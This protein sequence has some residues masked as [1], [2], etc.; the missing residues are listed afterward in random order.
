M[1]SIG[2]VVAGTFDGSR[3]VRP[4]ADEHW[5]AELKPISLDFDPD[6]LAVSGLDRDRLLIEG[7]DCAEAM[8]DLAKWVSSIAGRR[9]PVLAAYPLSYDW[10]FLYWYFVRFSTLG[11]PF[12]HSRCFD[13]KTAYAVKGRRTIGRSGRDRLPSELRSSLA[14]THHALDDAREQAEIFA[15]LFEWQPG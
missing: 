2:V 14:H 9:T 7:R 11:C 10:T 1:L 3:F 15:R 8:T 13:M 5:Y 6:A 12:K 4:S